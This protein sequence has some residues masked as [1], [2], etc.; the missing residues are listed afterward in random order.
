MTSNIHFFKTH[1]EPFDKI[2][3]G[4]KS[5]EIRKDDRAG[6]PGVGDLLI[7]REW[8]PDHREYTGRQVER[9]VTYVTEP[10]TWGLPTDVYVMSI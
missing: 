2:L 7:L 6:R 3:Q 5:H 1:P 9:R 8:C 4:A 10:G